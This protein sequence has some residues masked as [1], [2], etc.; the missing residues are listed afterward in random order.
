[1]K[2]MPNVETLSEATSAPTSPQFTN[3]ILPALKCGV[4]FVL[5]YSFEFEAFLLRSLDT[6]DGLGH[7]VF[8][9]PFDISTN[10][11]LV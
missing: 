7:I 2:T 5:R 3:D 6:S 9:L 1:M 8:I 4:S 11:R 10:L